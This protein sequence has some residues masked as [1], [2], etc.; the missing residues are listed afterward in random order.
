MEGVADT[1]DA[2]DGNKGPSARDRRKCLNKTETRHLHLIKHSANTIA[3]CV[4]RREGRREGWLLGYS[5]SGNIWAGRYL[6][7]LPRSVSVTLLSI[8]ILNKHLDCYLLHVT[9]ST[10]LPYVTNNVIM[11]NVCI[12][13]ALRNSI[14]TKYYVNIMKAL[15]LNKAVPN[16]WSQYGE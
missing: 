13:A 16:H 8:N 3:E 9:S 1:E 14:K 6:H 15:G 2:Y 10:E 7:T 5:L 4:E 11:N 12:V